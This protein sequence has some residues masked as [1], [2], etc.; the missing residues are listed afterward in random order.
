MEILLNE[1]I[2]WAG[3]AFLFW[4]MKDNMDGVET[5]LDADTPGQ[6]GHPRG[7]LHFDQAEQLT[8]PIGSYLNAPIY[9]HARIDG[10]DYEFSYAFPHNGGALRLADGERYLQPGLVYQPA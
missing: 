7:P 8:E 3:L 5:G 2:L 6:A 1:L 4:V 9:R 10:K